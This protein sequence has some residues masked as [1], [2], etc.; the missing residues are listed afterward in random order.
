MYTYLVDGSEW[1]SLQIA[2]LLQIT[3][4]ICI[5]TCKGKKWR[6][7]FEFIKHEHAFLNTLTKITALFTDIKG[8]TG[9][10]DLALSIM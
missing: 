1:S 10:A 7:K 8:L 2:S 9:A 6:M 5:F 3:K 4:N